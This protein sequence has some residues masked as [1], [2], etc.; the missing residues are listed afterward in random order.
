MKFGKISSYCTLDILKE[1]KTMAD[2]LVSLEN[3]IQG[4]IS[5]Q[6]ST[7]ANKVV[8]VKNTNN[9]FLFGIVIALGCVIYGVVQYKSQQSTAWQQQPQSQNLFQQQPLGNPNIQQQNINP[10]LNVLTID[11]KVDSLKKQYENVDQAAQKIW[12]V[13]KWNR[14][15][16]TLLATLN[17]QNSF[18]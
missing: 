13:T 11:Q 17:N 6:K 9:L 18:S 4:I 5:T 1:D 2:W 8:P 3:E 12:E 14:D 15:R 7:T 10:H 16:I